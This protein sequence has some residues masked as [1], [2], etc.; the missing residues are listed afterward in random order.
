M[1]ARVQFLGSVDGTYRWCAQRRGAPRRAPRAS[2]SPRRRRHEAKLAR[3]RAPTAARN[4]ALRLQLPALRD[5]ITRLRWEGAPL[6]ASFDLVVPPPFPQSTRLSWMCK[7]IYLSDTRKGVWVLHAAG[8]RIASR[9]GRSSAARR[10]YF[11]P[12][13]RRCSQRPAAGE[14]RRQQGGGQWRRPEEHCTSGRSKSPFAGRRRGRGIKDAGR[15][16]V[17]LCV[18]CVWYMY[19]CMGVVWVG[20]LQVRERGEREDG[21]KAGRYSSGVW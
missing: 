4:A 18:V 16:K 1:I 12:A 21:A 11:S 20:S 8:V 17:S 14:Q 10:A 2:S 6:A 5:S 3:A 19:V 7:S 15:V 9:A 13:R